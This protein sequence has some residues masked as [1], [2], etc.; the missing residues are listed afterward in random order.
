LDNPLLD[1]PDTKSTNSANTILVVDDEDLVRDLVRNILTRH[2]YCVRAVE[3]GYVALEQI[4]DDVIAVVTDLR[5]PGLTGMELLVQL[6]K[7]RPMLPA[8]LMSGY[9][10]ET[11]FDTLDTPNTKFIKKP[12]RSLQVLIDAVRA[13]LSSAA[14]DETIP[15][16]PALE[17]NSSPE[18]VQ[19][20]ADASAR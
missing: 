4:T 20:P 11:E 17:F 16:T 13:V 14:N 12:F 15:D 1:R 8:V 7:L 6:R 19:S 10:G 9:T 3:N 18:P 5:M 2:G